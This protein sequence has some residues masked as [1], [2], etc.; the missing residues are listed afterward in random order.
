M[1]QTS[2]AALL[3]NECR[4][5]PSGC[6]TCSSHLVD[7]ALHFAAYAGCIAYCCSGDGK[8][9]TMA[10]GAP[11]WAVVVWKWYS[12]KVSV[13]VSVSQSGGGWAGQ[14]MCVVAVRVSV[15]VASCC[16]YISNLGGKLCTGPAAAAQ[17]STNARRNVQL[18]VWLQR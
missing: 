17:L 11:D 4:C 13:G 15:H 16:M 10:C 1:G 5:A 8:L 3:A 12:S 2:A 9:L 18:V 6:P 14:D 7:I